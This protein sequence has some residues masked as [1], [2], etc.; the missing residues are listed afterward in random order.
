MVS[1]LLGKGLFS[2]EG[3]V[4]SLRL[5]LQLDGKQVYSLRR[6]LVK[7]QM[8]NIETSANKTTCKPVS[9]GLFFLLFLPSRPIEGC[10]NLIHSQ[11]GHILAKMKFPVF[12]LCYKNF[13]CVIF[14]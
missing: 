5:Q 2:S 8:T 9:K 13:P 6:S 12:S 7:L 10:G 3:Q 14:T 1:L 11:G 4:F